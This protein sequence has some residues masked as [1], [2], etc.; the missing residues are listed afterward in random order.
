MNNYRLLL[1]EKIKR[2]RKEKFL[3]QERFA[4]LVNRSK[5]HISKIEQ[6]LA[7]PPLSLL[8]DIANILQVHPCELFNFD[9]YLLTLTKIN[10]KNEFDSIKD[11]KHLEILYKIHKV[12]L[13]ESV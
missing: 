3:T 12:L 6:G 1:G 7:N 2:L 10:I 11:K 5:N 8:L 13:S 9:D 4:E